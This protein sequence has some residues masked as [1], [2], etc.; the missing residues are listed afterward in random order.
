MVDTFTSYIQSKTSASS[1]IENR[2]LIKSS[3][4]EL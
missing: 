4:T 2:I 1:Y 3:K